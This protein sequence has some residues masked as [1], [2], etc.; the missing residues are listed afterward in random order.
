MGEGGGEV[1]REGGSMERAS[2]GAGAA[3]TPWASSPQKGTPGHC[4]VAQVWDRDGNRVVDIEPTSD[5]ED[6]SRLAARIAAAV[7]A[8]AGT[9]YSV[10]DDVLE[11]RSRQDAQWG[12]AE[13]DDEHSVFEWYGFIEHQMELLAVEQQGH[14]VDDIPAART[15]LVKIAALAAAAIESL[16]RRVSR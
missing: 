3:P 2:Q 4:M 13:H 6:A 11:E 10:F 1:M 12:G 16:D 8:T 7:N 9:D 5:P 15:R 14:D